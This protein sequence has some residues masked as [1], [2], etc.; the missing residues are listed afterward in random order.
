MT[1]EEFLA[2]VTAIHRYV[3]EKEKPMEIKEIPRN[4]KIAARFMR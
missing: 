2:A 1:P 4:W 3:S